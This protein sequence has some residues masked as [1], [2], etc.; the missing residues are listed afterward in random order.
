MKPLTFR[1]HHIGIPTREK[2][3]SEAYHE[4]LKFFHSGYETSDFGIEW[5][6]YEDDS[7]LP[8]LV[9]TV[10]HVAFVVHNLDDALKGRHIIVE[11]NSPSEGVRVAMIEENGAPIEFLEFTSPD[12]ER[13]GHGTMSHG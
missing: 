13:K 8:E 6:R 9:K 1:Y 3:G 7:P 10:P 2:K 4:R 5:M 12:T 11:P